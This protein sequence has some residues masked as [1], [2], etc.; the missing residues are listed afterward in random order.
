MPCPRCG[1]S[2]AGEV[3]DVGTIFVCPACKLE[4]VESMPLDFS[5]D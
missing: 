4:W 5:N 2:S 3:T 1:T